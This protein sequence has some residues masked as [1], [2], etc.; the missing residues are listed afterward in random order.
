M[1]RIYLDNA[2]TTFP[3]PP[4]VPAAMSD[5]ISNHGV[6]I[7]RGSYSPAYDMEEL[8]YTTRLWLAQLFN[9]DDCKN[10]IF[11]ANVTT[12]LNIVL[13]GLLKPGDHVLVSSM[14]HNAV[15]RP[16]VQLEQQGVTF[17][18]IPCTAMGELE[19]ERLP[20]LLK[21]TTKAVIM[22][23][24]SNVCGT[25]MP[26]A[27]VGA[28]CQE[29]GLL[30]IVDSAQTAGVLPLD[31]KAMHIDALCF[32]GHKGLLGPQGIGGFV[33]T[34]AVAA[35]MTPLIAGGT[36][37]VSHTEEMPDFLPDKF[38]SGTLNLPGIVGLH[39]ALAYI[40]SV[41]LPAIHE[42]EMA[43]T[44][45]FLRGLTSIPGL[46]VIGRPNTTNRTAV[47]SIAATNQDNAIVAQELEDQYG[48][49]T[50]VGLHCAPSAHKT[51]GTF[52]SGTIRFSFGHYNT[53]AEIDTAL[54][55]LRKL[56]K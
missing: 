28:F 8:V 14:E 33:V 19:L 31:M 40:R 52:P 43:L 10:V 53:P 4:E 39:A 25:L 46:A 37:S 1:K 49:M 55:A 42:K 2:C 24:S 16:L 22:T 23:H 9:Y 27:D 47:V 11:T 48:I 51:L 13:K 3:K 34:D 56:C 21:D 20:A 54:Q 17:D 7:N 44:D 5:F 32:T 26:L 50:R 45:Q 29:H 18:R 6:N 15:M 38:E 35:A 12:S 41:G 30:F 36:G